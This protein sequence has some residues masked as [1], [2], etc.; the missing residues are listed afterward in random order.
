MIDLLR[1][2]IPTLMQKWGTLFKHVENLNRFDTPTELMWLAEAA[3]RSSAILECGAHRGISTKLM[4][5]ANPKAKIVVLDAWHDEDCFEFFSTLLSTEIASGQVTPIQ[6]LT[7]DGF[8]ILKKNL[9][10]FHPDFAFIDASHLYPDVLHDIKNTLTLMQNGGI[11]SGHDYRHNLPDDGVT[12]SVRE[13]F[14]KDFS[15][16]V[17]SIWVKG[18]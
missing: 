1:P 14:G 15:L 13:A 16:P 8:E 17:D 9:P 10:D 6:G 12:R 5:L 11:I 2:D 4:A 7:N 3:S 18:L